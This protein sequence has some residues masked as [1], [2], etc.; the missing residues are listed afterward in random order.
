MYPSPS[1]AVII[2]GFVEFIQVKISQEPRQVIRIP[3]YGAASVQRTLE[4]SV[5]YVS[6]YRA[7]TWPQQDSLH[8]VVVHDIVN[9][10]KPFRC[11]DYPAH[12]LQYGDNVICSFGISIQHA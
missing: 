7:A 11:L 12:R 1:A 4:Y 10:R 9:D 2:Q 5:G 6:P 3:A 8:Q